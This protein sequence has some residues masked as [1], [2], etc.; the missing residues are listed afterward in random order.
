MRN[1]TR[2]NHQIRV[3]TVRCV[4]AEGEQ[5]GVI[6]ISQALNMARAA[7]LDL[8]EVAAQSQPPVCRI[9]DY[10]KFKYEQQKREAEARK[11][12]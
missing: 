3:P 1:Y 2:I 5:I 8:V 11:K 6:P 12:Q 4:D 10:G 7:G 9:M